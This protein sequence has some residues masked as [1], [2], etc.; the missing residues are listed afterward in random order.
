MLSRSLARTQRCATS[1]E[2]RPPT[3]LA[4][5]PRRPS[6]RQRWSPLCSDDGASRRE[7]LTL[8]KNGAFV[9]ALG[10]LNRKPH[11]INTQSHISGWTV[12]H[13]AAFHGCSRVLFG[14]LLTSGACPRLRGYFD[15][16]TP[17]DVLQEHHPD[18]PAI[19]DLREREGDSAGDSA[20]AHTT[21]LVD[22][23]AVSCFDSSTQA[24]VCGTVRRVDGAAGTVTVATSEGEE[25]TF[26]TWRTWAVPSAASVDD[27]ATEEACPTCCEPL[28]LLLDASRTHHSEALSLSLSHRSP[29]SPSIYPLAPSLP[30]RHLLRQ[31]NLLHRQALPRLHRACSSALL[32]VPRPLPWAEHTS[33]NYPMRC[34]SPRPFPDPSL[35]SSPD[36]SPDRSPTA[37]AL[38][39]DTPRPLRMESPDG[40]HMESAHLTH[41]ARATACAA[42]KYPGCNAVVDLSGPLFGRGAAQHWPPYGVQTSLTTLS[43]F[44][45]IAHA[46]TEEVGQSHHDTS[47]FL[48]MLAEAPPIERPIAYCNVVGCPSKRACPAC[49]VV[50]EYESACKHFHCALCGHNFCFICLKSHA[51]HPDGQW[52]PSFPARSRRCR[53]SC[54]GCRRPNV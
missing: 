48:Q 44:L 39:G 14:R 22:G 16:R 3:C 2:R 9:E 20:A 37:S 43:A 5:T 4:T 25:R 46:K 10:I 49:G 6:S 51:E 36:P 32:R 23:A 28:V 52:S 19:A 31:R 8:A 12:L 42:G 7:L 15:G 13:Q 1:R 45:E 30:R 50:I 17:L 40:I 54:P 27:E 38:I 33:L 41:R 24:M 47:V 11:L 26:P 18:H 53:P 35:P 29:L 34:Q 21:A